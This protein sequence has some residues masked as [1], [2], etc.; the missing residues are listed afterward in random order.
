MSTNAGRLESFITDVLQRDLSH[1]SA[2]LQK[3]NTEIEELNQLASSV[4]NIQKHWFA[5]K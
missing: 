2:H 4:K 1:Y 5:Q 3:I